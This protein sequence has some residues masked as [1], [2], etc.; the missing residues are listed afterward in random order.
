MS[1]EHQD[2]GSAAD[3]LKQFQKDHCYVTISF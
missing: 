1:K 3:A 2:M